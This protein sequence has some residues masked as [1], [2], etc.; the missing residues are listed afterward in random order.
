MNM[1]RP[2]PMVSE[3]RDRSP[4]QER[5]AMIMTVMAWALAVCI[6]ASSLGAWMLGGLPNALITLGVLA[7]VVAV[8]CVFALMINDVG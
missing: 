1:R 8:C 4:K 7:G 3:A 6:G 5:F 2:N